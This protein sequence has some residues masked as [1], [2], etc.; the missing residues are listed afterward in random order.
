MNKTRCALV[1][2]QGEEWVL[3]VET[4]LEQV[5]QVVETADVMPV[6]E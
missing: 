2:M 3:G 5:H 4:I 1:Q 6:V